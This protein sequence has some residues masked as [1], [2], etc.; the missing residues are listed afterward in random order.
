MAS[1]P[2]AWL[3]QFLPVT[4]LWLL[5]FSLYYCTVLILQYKT[6]WGN[7]YCDLVLYKKFNLFDGHCRAS[8]IIKFK[9]L[10]VVSISV[11]FSGPSKWIMLLCTIACIWLAST[12]QFCWKRSSYVLKEKKNCYP[13]SFWLKP[14]VLVPL[15]IRNEWG[16]W[17]EAL[18]SVWLPTVRII[19]WK[20]VALNLEELQWS[21]M[22]KKKITD[23]TVQITTS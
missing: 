13:C 8:V 5:G 21:P 17:V 11:S 3:C 14:F 22:V 16:G 2:W 4:V 12:A 6:P 18:L 10:F 1:P 20:A 15:W 9:H 23:K 7:R 19:Q